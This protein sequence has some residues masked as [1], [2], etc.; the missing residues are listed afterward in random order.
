MTHAKKAHCLSLAN[1]LIVIL[2]N[3]TDEA[4]PMLNS[5]YIRLTYLN[6]TFHIFKVG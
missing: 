3:L 6:Q 1:I 5:T 4:M 2:L